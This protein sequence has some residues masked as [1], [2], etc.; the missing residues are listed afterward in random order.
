MTQP[1]AVKSH[2][3]EQSDLDDALD[4]TF[5]ASDSPSQTDPT[6]GVVAGHAEPTE[7]AV[8]QR[9]YE[10][11]QREGST[12]GSHDEHWEQAQRELEADARGTLASG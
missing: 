4:D 6:H 8:R 10:I 9:A 3:T 11:W 2:L 7:D 1:D 5:P 12:H